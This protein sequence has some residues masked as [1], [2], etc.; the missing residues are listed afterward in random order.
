MIRFK[1][2]L[3]M[4]ATRIPNSIQIVPKICDKI[5]INMK[6]LQRFKTKTVGRMQ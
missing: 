2:G 1:N 3:K 5:L 6:I 4:I